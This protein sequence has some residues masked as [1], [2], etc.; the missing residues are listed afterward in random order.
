MLYHV[1]GDFESPVLDPELERRRGFL[2][3]LGHISQFLMRSEFTLEG[4]DKWIT[5]LKDFLSCQTLPPENVSILTKAGVNYYDQYLLQ[6][7][8]YFNSNNLPMTQENI[9]N[10]ICLDFLRNNSSLPVAEDRKDSSNDSFSCAQHAKYQIPMTFSYEHLYPPY[11][12]M[13]HCGSSDPF[14]INFIES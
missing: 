9:F 3:C 12:S 1:V 8:K 2:A 4:S 13:H 10:Q 14:S 7:P 5:G 6:R 11:D